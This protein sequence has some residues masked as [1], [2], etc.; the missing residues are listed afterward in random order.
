[1]AA[2][3]SR[4]RSALVAGV[5][6]SAAEVDVGAVV[7]PSS[8]VAVDW[9]VAAVGWWWFQPAAP[10]WSTRPVPTTRR[11]RPELWRSPDRWRRTTQF[12]PTVRRSF[13]PQDEPIERWPWWP[14]QRPP[15]RPHQTV[16]SSLGASTFVFADRKVQGLPPARTPTI[17]NSVQAIRSRAAPVTILSHLPSSPK[18]LPRS[19]HA[20]CLWVVV[21]TESPHG[22]VAASGHAPRLPTASGC[23]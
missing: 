4:A 9:V 16:I 18:S 13:P 17:N 2:A 19:H 8:S 20:G 22:M 6:T 10:S 3:F 12:P 5:V 21:P 1:M 14:R 15:F 11:R 7:V 23:C